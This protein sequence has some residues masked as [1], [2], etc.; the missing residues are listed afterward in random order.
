MPNPDLAKYNI[1]RQKGKTPLSVKKTLRM[2]QAMAQ[3]IN[4]G[5]LDEDWTDIALRAIA[6][7]LEEKGI[8]LE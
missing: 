8:V 7:A 5:V 1:E 3:A 6:K 4:A 2:E